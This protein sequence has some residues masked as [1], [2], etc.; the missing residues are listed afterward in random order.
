MPT[1]TQNLDELQRELL[2]AGRQCYQAN[3]E[4]VH[5]FTTAAGR[6]REAKIRRAAEVVDV[7]TILPFHVSPSALAAFDLALADVNARLAFP[8]LRRSEEGY[9]AYII[10]QWLNHDG[11]IDAMVVMDAIATSRQVLDEHEPG[12]AAVAKAAGEAARA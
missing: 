9:V 6:K 1:W 2:A 5:A 4:L 10:R 11:T 12:L 7:L 8:G 3:G